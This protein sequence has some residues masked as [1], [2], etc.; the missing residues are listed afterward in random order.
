MNLLILGASRGYGLLL[1]DHFHR[2]GD[3]VFHISRNLTTPE[4]MEEVDR[5]FKIDLHSG[6]VLRPA[7]RFIQQDIKLDAFISCVHYDQHIHDYVF[8]TDFYKAFDTNIWQPFC[9]LRLLLDYSC[10]RWDGKAVFFLDSRSY[11]YENF[12][13]GA[14]KA[15]QKPFLDFASSCFPVTF[16]HAYFTPLNRDKRGAAD[17]TLKRFLEFFQSD[18]EAGEHI[19]AVTAT[20][21]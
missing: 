6:D 21:K 18:F 9:L 13:T 10:I 2:Q 16:K 1:R 3:Q 17:Y 11:G 8:A 19:N 5:W 4:D 15:C 7:E 12:T 20:A 14:A